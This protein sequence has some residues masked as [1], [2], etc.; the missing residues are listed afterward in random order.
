MVWMP[1]RCPRCHSDV[2]GKRCENHDDA[3]VPC[4]GMSAEDAA[5]YATREAYAR[6]QID[7]DEMQR[8]IEEALTDP[9]R[10]RFSLITVCR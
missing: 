1:A 5:L 7:F 2:S 4:W 8:R 10:R 3:G 9:P 6:G